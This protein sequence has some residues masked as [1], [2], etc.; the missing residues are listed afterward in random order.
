MGDYDPGLVPLM[1][2]AEMPEEVEAWLTGSADAPIETNTHRVSP[3]LRLQ[4]RSPLLSRETP[5]RIW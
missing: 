4:M 3:R 2:P 1:R 5:P